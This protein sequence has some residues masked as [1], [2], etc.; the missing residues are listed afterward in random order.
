MEYLK[1]RMQYHSLIETS[2]LCYLL[3]SRL[4]NMDLHLGDYLISGR[5]L[6]SL[7]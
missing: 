3:V 4:G 1:F 2:I 5:G 7:K 6:S